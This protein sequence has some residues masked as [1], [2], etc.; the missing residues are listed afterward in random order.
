MAKNNT[1]YFSHDSNALSDI[2]IAAMRSDYGLEGY[3]I[4]LDNYR[5]VKEWIYI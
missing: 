3:R 2:K 4:I 1:Y 5:N